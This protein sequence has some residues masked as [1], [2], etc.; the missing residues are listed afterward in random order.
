MEVAQELRKSSVKEGGDINKP[1]AADLGLSRPSDQ[2][3]EKQQISGKKSSSIF[4][5][6]VI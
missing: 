1:A 6:V 2:Q 5:T 4:V 3:K